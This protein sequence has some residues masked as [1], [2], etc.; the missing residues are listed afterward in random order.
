[1]FLE[2]VDGLICIGKFSKKEIKE[3]IGICKNIV[4]LDM[5]VEEYQNA[6]DIVGSISFD[7]QSLM[8]KI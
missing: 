4:F 2:H 6:N 5:T 8:V 3:F 7:R 1:M